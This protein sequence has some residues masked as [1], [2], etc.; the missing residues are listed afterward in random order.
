M[1]NKL[2]DKGKPIPEND[3][4][5]AAVA[6]QNNLILVTRDAHFS[7]IAEILHRDWKSVLRDLKYLEGFGLVELVKEGRHRMVDIVSTE[8][9]M[10][11]T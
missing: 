1:K 9:V 8:Q 3:I 7:E 11:F 2:L 10:A 6:M 4:W 5:I